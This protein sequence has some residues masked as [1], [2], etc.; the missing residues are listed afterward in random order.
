MTTVYTTELECDFCRTRVK[1]YSAAHGN[2]FRVTSMR[3]PSTR[4]IVDTNDCPA[5]ADQMHACSVC[6]HTIHSVLTKLGIPHEFR[7][8]QY[9][10]EPTISSILIPY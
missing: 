3:L 10:K 9:D 2:W 6:G 8:Y 5:E 1:N 7:C 4:A